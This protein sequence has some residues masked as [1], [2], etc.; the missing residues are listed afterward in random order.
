M[1][2]LLFFSKI[3]SG[4]GMDSGSGF[5]SGMGMGMGSDVSEPV[6]ASGHRLAR[7]YCKEC[8]GDHDCSVCPSVQQGRP[9][10]ANKRVV[11]IRE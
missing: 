7:Q 9:V 1:S 2:F 10:V 11:A 8:T 6:S 4:V 5:T 3:D